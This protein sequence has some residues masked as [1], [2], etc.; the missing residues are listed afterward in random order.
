MKNGRRFFSLF[1]R[2]RHLKHIHAQK[3]SRIVDNTVSLVDAVEKHHCLTAREPDTGVLRY[4]FRRTEENYIILSSFA[5]I[6]SP[7]C[8]QGIA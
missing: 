2:R 5:A 4:E 8:I 1:R 7:L 6:I 3:C